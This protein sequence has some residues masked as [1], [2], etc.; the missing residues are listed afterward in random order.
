[1]SDVDVVVVGGGPTGLLLAGDLARA[2]R[3]VTVLE[4]H[5]T[6]SPLSRAFGVH[7]RTLELLDQRDLADHLA[8]WFGEPVGCSAALL[9]G[10]V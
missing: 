6:V 3:S 9:G 4:R 5:P 1:M 10:T 7:A 2:G 8:R